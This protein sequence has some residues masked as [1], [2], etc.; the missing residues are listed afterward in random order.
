MIYVYQENMTEFKYSIFMRVQLSL[1]KK[2]QE[3]KGFT[4]ISLSLV[5]SYICPLITSIEVCIPLFVSS[6]AICLLPYH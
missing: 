6:T 1:C 3:L 5:S 4:V 2:K